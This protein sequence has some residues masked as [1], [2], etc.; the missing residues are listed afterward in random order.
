MRLGGVVD[1]VVRGFCRSCFAGLVFLLLSS[2]L[3]GWESDGCAGVVG[4]A[5]GN[6]RALG[7][8]ENKDVGDVGEAGAGEVGAEEEREEETYECFRSQW[9]LVFCWLISVFA[10][11]SWWTATLKRFQKLGSRVV[12]VFVRFLRLVWCGMV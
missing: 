4:Y 10:S 2:L 12:I 7:T 11:S 5:S 8:G 1:V 6:V 9:L 3:E